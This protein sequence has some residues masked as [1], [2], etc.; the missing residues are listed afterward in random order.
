MDSR[1]I[2]E[3]TGKEHSNVCRDIR[4]MLDAAGIPGFSFESGYLDAQG[5]SR[6]C[7]KLPAHELMLLLTGYSVPLRDKVLRRWEELERAAS[8]SIPKTYAAALQLAADQAKEIEAQAAKL[9]EA[10]PKIESFEALMR[11]D[12]T[13]SVTDAA[14]HFGLHPILEVFPYLRAKGYLTQSDLPTQAAIDAGY[15]SLKE[16]KAQSGRIFPQAVV[17]AWQL[18][19]WRAHVVHQ[20]KHFVADKGQASA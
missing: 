14:K 4:A 3:R 20:I 17:E 8:P 18:E 16:N 12:R 13:M 19:N 2:A 11:S 15:L 9:A 5:Q 6:K 7:Y 10:A 1:E